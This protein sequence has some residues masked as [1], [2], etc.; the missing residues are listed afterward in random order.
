MFRP[1]EITTPNLPLYFPLREELRTGDCIAF[2]GTG[3]VS[4]VIQIGTGS[5]YSHVAMVFCAMPLASATMRNYI[6]ES[7]SLGTVSDAVT[8]KMMV[9]VQFHWLS[10]LLVSTEGRAW[11]VKA[12]FVLDGNEEH[13]LQE[14]LS[15]QHGKPYDFHQALWSGLDAMDWIGLENDPDTA[16]LFCSELMAAGLKHAKVQGWEHVNYS[17]MTPHDLVR[18]Y[19]SEPVLILDNM[20]EMQPEPTEE[21]GFDIGG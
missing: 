12:P 14:W 3:A 10:R 7:T 20:P 17:E 19:G 4:Q 9:G 15:R 1:N 21:E 5:P 2:Q 6:I 13:D 18:K 11:W 16:M 8:G